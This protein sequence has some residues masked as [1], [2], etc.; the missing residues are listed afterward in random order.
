MV[1]NINCKIHVLSSTER[2][3]QIIQLKIVTTVCAIAHP[4]LCPESTQ[5]S[6]TRVCLLFLKKKTQDFASSP[7]GQQQ[8]T[9]DIIAT[10]WPCGQQGTCFPH[11]R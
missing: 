9:P 10:S 8:S 6:L 11:T 7:A 2:T 5:T 4:L 1:L 3:K